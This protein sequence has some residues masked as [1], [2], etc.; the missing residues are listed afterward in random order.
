[1]V[2]VV[3]VADR[4]APRDAVLVAELAAER[5]AG[6]RRVGDHAA[7][8]DD[9]GD[10]GDRALL[11]AGRVDVEV[12]GH[13]KSLGFLLPAR[14]RGNGGYGDSCATTSSTT[15]ATTRRTPCSGRCAQ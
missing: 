6:V 12:P 15:S 1:M 13:A 9:I 7:P 10:L 8:A 3:Q 2:P 11:R 4:P 5:V 14:S